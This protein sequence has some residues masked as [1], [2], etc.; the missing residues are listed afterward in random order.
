MRVVFTTSIADLSI[1]KVFLQVLGLSP[2]PA[3]LGRRI[4]II[5][6]IRK[7]QMNKVKQPTPATPKKIHKLKNKPPFFLKKVKKVKM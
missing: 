2:I 1:I 3:I 5:L 6:K 4:E 7:Q